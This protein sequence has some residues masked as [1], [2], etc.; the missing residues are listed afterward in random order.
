MIFKT[1]KPDGLN[2]DYDLD[3]SGVERISMEFAFKAA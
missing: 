3:L 1:V 2:I